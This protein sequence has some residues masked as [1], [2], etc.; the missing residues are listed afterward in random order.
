M[1]GL[2]T[3]QVSGFNLT[4]E[5]VEKDHEPERRADIPWNEN[6][7]YCYRCHQ[8]HGRVV[9]DEQWRKWKASQ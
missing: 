6:L 1:R 8:Y 7:P 2:R 4:I 9:R 5:P 3:I